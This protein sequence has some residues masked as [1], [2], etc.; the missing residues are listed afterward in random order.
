MVGSF[1]TILYLALVVCA[2][3]FI[4]LLTDT[5]VIARDDAGVALGPAMAAAAVAVVLAALVVRVPKMDFTHRRSAPAFSVVAG[6]FAGVAYGVVGAIGYGVS[7]GSL[8]AGVPFLGETAIGWYGIAVTVL[9][10]L[11]A[12]LDTVVVAA[13]FDDRGRPRWFWEDEHDV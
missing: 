8:L 7:S 9:A 10:A 5:E 3:G 1:A 2:F 13:R 12:W 6:V 11:V 4:S